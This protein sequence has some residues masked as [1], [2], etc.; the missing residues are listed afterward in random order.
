MARTQKIA[1]THTYDKESDVLY[2][3]FGD[4]E[5]TYVENI[6]DMLLLEIGW[7]SGLPKGLRVIGVK[8]NNIAAIGGIIVKRFTTQAKNLMEKRRKLIKQQEPAVVNMRDTLS[9]IFQQTQRA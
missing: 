1:L 2:I 5:P 4:E 6:D 8:S 9:S 7:F 3:T